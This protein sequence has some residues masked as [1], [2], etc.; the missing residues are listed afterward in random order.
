MR[1]VS[2]NFSLSRH[3]LVAALAAAL[4]APMHAQAAPTGRQGKAPPP[5]KPGTQGTPKAPVAPKPVAPPPAPKKG[6]VPGD[7][8][9]FL[10]KLFDAEAVMKQ[11]PTVTLKSGDAQIKITPGDKGQD[12]DDKAGDRLYSAPAE[13]G[14]APGGAV[15]VTVQSAGL[16][17]TTVAQ[18]DP[19]EKDPALVFILRMEGVISRTRTSE[20][21]RA[22]G[23]GSAPTSPKAG[24]GQPPKPGGAGGAPKAV[25]GGTKVGQGGLAG[26][27][28]SAGGGGGTILP[29]NKSLTNALWLVLAAWGFTALGFVWPR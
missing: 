12:T 29:S 9:I 2:L 18:L 13:L 27:E 1:K 19:E 4:L 20:L 28:V 5:P 7:A 26:G 3:L 21:I 22:A 23:E 16:T 6:G 14:I 8:T 25:T 11:P 24:V 15:K 10:V 17:W